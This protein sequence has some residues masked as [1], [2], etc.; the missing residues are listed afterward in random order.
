MRYDFSMKSPEWFD[1]KNYI[2]GDNR[3]HWQVQIVQRLHL[4]DF[5]LAHDKSEL[6]SEYFPEKLKHIMGI[7]VS[8]ENILNFGRFASVRFLD[9]DHLS[10]IRGWMMEPELKDALEQPLKLKEQPL[11]P[12]ALLKMYRYGQRSL[13]S[14]LKDG[15]SKNMPIV[16]DPHADMRS[17]LHD[18]EVLVTKMRKATSTPLFKKP[19]GRK[20]FADWF[21]YG[22]LPCWDLDLWCQLTGQTMTNAEL[23]DLLWPNAN[24]DR[25][26]RVRKTT[27]AKCWEI[28]SDSTFERLGYT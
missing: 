12:E 27:K 15:E 14:I 17:I 22:I 16:I 28:V 11:G 8:E 1:L 13:Q 24:F 6:P 20:E 10:K 9:L 5:C 23:G 4:R 26:E 18:V 19:V 21:T 2:S 7:R 25:A 3:Y